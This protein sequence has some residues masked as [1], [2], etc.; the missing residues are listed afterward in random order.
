MSRFIVVATLIC[1]M[2]VGI[3]VWNGETGLI[4]RCYMCEGKLSISHQLIL[5]VC[6]DW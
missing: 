6:L 1:K 3:L 2:G 4:N 5:G